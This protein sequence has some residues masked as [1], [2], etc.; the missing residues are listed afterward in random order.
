MRRSRGRE[1]ASS[2]SRND[3]DESGSDEEAKIPL[4]K[5]RDVRAKLE[6]LRGLVAKFAGAAGAIASQPRRDILAD[7]LGEEGSDPDDL[8]THLV[9]DPGGTEAVLTEARRT[10]EGSEAGGDVRGESA[11]EVGGGAGCETKRPAVAVAAPTAPAPAAAALATVVRP[12]LVTVAARFV[13]RY[14]GL[15][16]FRPVQEPDKFST[17]EPAWFADSLDNAFRMLRPPSAS[18][19]KP[20][21]VEYKMRE[22]R[23]LRIDSKSVA[24]V[25]KWMRDDAPEYNRPIDNPVHVLLSMLTQAE[26]HQ[27]KPLLTTRVSAGDPDET[28]RIQTAFLR[29]VHVRAPLQRKKALTLASVSVWRIW[30]TAFRPSPE[31]PGGIRHA[32]DEAND[33]IL[34]DL[35]CREG[36]DGLVLGEWGRGAQALVCAPAQKTKLALV[37]TIKY[38]DAALARFVL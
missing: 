12:S 31:G 5:S 35:L 3:D 6:L 17:S 2:D 30:Q 24:A 26:L 9:L 27:L 28:R 20:T 36:L 25:D 1:R 7:I 13:T 29:Q 21:I 33:A 19:F 4:K 22:L 18:E 32:P 23:L 11:G 14:A 16:V 37:G 15:S 34:G 38:D 8:L 10:L